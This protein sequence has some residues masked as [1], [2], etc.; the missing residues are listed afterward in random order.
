[1]Y[2]SDSP[3]KK[4]SDDI[5]SRTN[6][7]SNLGKSL[8]DWS[9]DASIVIG[10]YGKWGSGKSSIINLACNTIIELEKKRRVKKK[11]IVVYFN[12]WN[13]SEQEKLVTTFLHE[14][15]KSIN[16]YDQ[17]EDAKRVGKELIAY[18]KLFTE[19]LAIPIEL[20][21]SA[22]PYGPLLLSFVKLIGKV[23]KNTG[24]TTKAWGEL[25]EKTVEQFKESLSE[26][27]RKL[28]RKIIVV[29]DDIDR[30]NNKEARQIF[31]LVKQ[32]ANFPSVIYI[33]PFDRTKV[34]KILDED[35]FPG[36][37]YLEKI[38]Q[39]PFDVPAVEQV[40]L[41]RFLFEKIDKLIKPFP[42]SIWDDKHWGNIYYSGLQK[43]FS[44][45]RQIKRFINSLEFNFSHIP[46]EVNPIDFMALEALRIF[47]PDV[48]EAIWRNKKVFTEL[49]SGYSSSGRDETARKEKIKKIIDLASDDYKEPVKEVLERLFPQIES[50]YGSDWIEEWNKKRRVCSEERFDRYFLMEVPENE[51]TQK[52]I[53]NIVKKSDSA[54]LVEKEILKLQKE[55]KAKN[56]LEKLVMYKDDVPEKNIFSFVLGVFNAAEKL[57]NDRKAMAILDTH[58]WGVRVGYHLFKRIQS[59]KDRLK[60]LLELIKKTESLE[61]LSNFVSIEIRREDK[62]ENSDHTYLIDETDIP[63]VRAAM[64]NKIKAHAHSKLLQKVSN[65]AYMLYF[66]EN[67]SNKDEVKKY[68]EDYIKTDHGLIGFIKGFA[69]TQSSIGMGDYVSKITQQVN[70]DSMKTFV[71][72]E[73]LKLRVEKILKDQAKKLSDDD[74]NTLTLFVESFTKKRF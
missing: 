43:F 58:S 19:T 5:L 27:I 50:G 29:I 21:V 61:V 20:A 60:Y 74:K 17:S 52:E 69:W 38:V 14:L 2:T 22:T 72:V 35:S 66:W 37:D 62:K 9:D 11:A 1:M 28:S 36:K 47:T 57:P 46:D 53:N 8:I 65:L 24:E 48:Y 12:P 31:Q 15:A 44:S 40:R 45:I 34:A 39:I 33:L 70:S 7:A 64:L 3:I 67:L 51:V 4:P 13:F 42:Q 26:K 23:F 55:N 59:S 49:S 63:K 6:F 25:K 56:F 10:L 71:D 18:S 41:D 68:V 16:H 32:N 73:K 30:L 54:A